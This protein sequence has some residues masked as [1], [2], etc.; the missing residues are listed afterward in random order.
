MTD[1]ELQDQHLLR[2]FLELH[3]DNSGVE[4]LHNDEKEEILITIHFPRHP[5]RTYQCQIDSDDEFYEFFW[6]E[7]FISFSLEERS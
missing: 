4:I 2:R 1:R 3:P 7:F 5:S 6:N